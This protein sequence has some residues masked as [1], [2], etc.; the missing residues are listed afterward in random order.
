LSAFPVIH[1][2]IVVCKARGWPGSLY[3]K[4][5]SGANIHVGVIGEA[6]SCRSIAAVIENKG[7]VRALEVHNGFSS[8]ADTV[9]CECVVTVSSPL[10]ASTTAFVIGADKIFA[11][12]ASDR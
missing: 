4:V 7:I 1:G 11:D 2:F 3:A 12:T 6:Q 10:P 9:A 8:P 5:A